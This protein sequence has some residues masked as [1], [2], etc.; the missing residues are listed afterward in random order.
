MVLGD[1]SSRMIV[2]VLGYIYPAYLSYKSLN[3]RKNDQIKEWCIYWFV[4]ALW[5]AA[6]RVADYVIFWIPLY[7]EAK[8]LTVLFLWHPKSR[9]ALYLY[10]TMFKPW[11]DTNQ[12][13]IDGR[14]EQGKTWVAG[15][16]TNHYNQGMNYLQGRAHE[17][18]AYMQQVSQRQQEQQ[19][20]ISRSGSGLSRSG[21]SMGSGFG[22]SRR[23]HQHTE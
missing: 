9:G 11:L 17:A 12:Q 13:M 5:T 7:Y 3:S 19:E 8:V 10:D 2:N 21:S 14:I 18:I 6:E 16:I 15:H 22:G 1:F 20:S 23:R 4:L